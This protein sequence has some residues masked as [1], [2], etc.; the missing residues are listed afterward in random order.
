MTMGPDTTSF[1]LCV[2]VLKEKETL[3]KRKRNKSSEL[4][5]QT[6]KKGPRELAGTTVLLQRLLGYTVVVLCLSVSAKHYGDVFPRSL[7]D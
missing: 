2:L 3:N 7:I 1:G 6:T 4:L 5:R